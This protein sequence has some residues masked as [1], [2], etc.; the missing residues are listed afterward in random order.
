MKMQLLNN[1]DN[2][3]H[4]VKVIKVLKKA[5]LTSA[6]TSSVYM[7]LRKRRNSLEYRSTRILLLLKLAVHIGFIGLFVISACTCLVLHNKSFFKSQSTEIAALFQI[8][9]D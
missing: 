7:L 8:H 1:A 3:N 2:T 4:K 6:K 9:V 5:M